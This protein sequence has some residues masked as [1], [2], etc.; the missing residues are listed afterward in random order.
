VRVKNWAPCPN[1]M[2]IQY[3]KAH[4]FSHALA[5]KYLPAQY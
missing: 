3:G 2:P 4:G 1:A 5:S